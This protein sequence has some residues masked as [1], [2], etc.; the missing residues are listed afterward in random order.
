MTP[1]NPHSLAHDLSEITGISLNDSFCSEMSK[2]EFAGRIYNLLDKKFHHPCIPVSES[3]IERLCTDE[4]KGL[5]VF[6]TSN[7]LN[8]QQNEVERPKCPVQTSSHQS[9]ARFD[10]K[11]AMLRYVESFGYVFYDSPCQYPA[12]F[13]EALANYCDR[14]NENR[15]MIESTS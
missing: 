12:S 14:M 2:Q 11:S 6:L 13:L 4:L 15:G 7:I 3:V 1:S 10:Y 8:R 9:L 5:Y